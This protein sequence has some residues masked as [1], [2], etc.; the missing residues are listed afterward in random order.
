MINRS[1]ILDYVLDLVV[2][3][4]LVFSLF[5]L[6]TGH[7][8]PGGGFVA[9]LV[10]GITIVLRFIALGR[11]GIEAALPGSPNLIMGLGLSLAIATGVGG[12]VWGESFLTS[13]KVD[14]ELPLLGEIHATSALPFDIGVFLVVVGLAAALIQALGSDE[15]PE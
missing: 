15:E 9:G 6:F 4:A 7:N 3:T 8:A 10:A 5:L 1:L 11:P 13:V 12:W 14:L 2:R